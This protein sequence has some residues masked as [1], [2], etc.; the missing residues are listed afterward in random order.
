MGTNEVSVVPEKPS[1]ERMLLGAGVL[2]GGQFALAGAP[3][4]HALDLSE[5]WPGILSVLVMFV[6]PIL[7]A[8]GTPYL[9]AVTSETFVR[10]PHAIAGDVV[11][12]ASF[13]VL[14]GDFWD[15]IR[16]LFVRRA[17]AGFPRPVG[18]PS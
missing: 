13:F 14:G 4:V 9:A 8:W 3:V 6:V 10:T 2:I 16:S 12:L 11:F 17:V 18:A 5:P 15:K 1:R 7:L